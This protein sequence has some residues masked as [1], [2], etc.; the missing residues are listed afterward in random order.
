[1]VPLSKLAGRVLAGIKPKDTEQDEVF[2]GRYQGTLL[3]AGNKFQKR[4]QQESDVGDFFIHA[5]RH[6][7][8]TKLAELRVPPHVRDLLLDHVPARG[9]GAGYDHHHYRE[10]LREA[11]EQWADYVERLVVPEGMRALR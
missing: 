5:C 11:V 8:E 3:S 10:E 2:V 1:M 4:V 6:T 7:V 9:A